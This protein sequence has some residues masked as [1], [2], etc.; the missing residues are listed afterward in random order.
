MPPINGNHSKQVK[1]LSS[2]EKFSWPSGK[3]LIVYHTNWSTYGRDYQVKDIPIEYISDINYAFYNLVKNQD[4]FYVPTTGDAWADMDQRFTTAEKGLSPL[5][6]WIK[7]EDFYGNFGQFRK[8]KENGHKF[9]LGLSVGGWS[10]SKNF[11]DALKDEESRH[12]FSDTIID[13]F[14]QYPIFNRIDLDWEYISPEGNSYGLPENGTRR[15]D[16]VNFGLFI[17]MLRE[18]FDRNGMEQYEITMCS[19]ADPKKLAILPIKEMV[20]YLDTINIMTYDFADGSWGLTRSTH[21]TNVYKT[22]YTPFSVEEAVDEFIRLGV[23]REKL[24]IGV[25]Y[26]SRGFSNT[27][28]INLPCSGGSTD[29]SW[30]KGV[31]DYKDLPLPGATEFYDELAGGAYSLDESKRILNTY[32]NPRSVIEKCKYVIDNDLKGII[33]WESSGDRPK[34]DDRCLT[35]IIHDN[36]SRNPIPIVSP[37]PKPVPVPAPRPVPPPVPIEEVI[38]KPPSSTPLIK[39]WMPFTK[40]NRNER[41]SYKEKVY[42]CRSQHVSQLDWKPDTT[43]TLWEKIGELLTPAPIPVPAPVKP[44]P[45]PRPIIIQPHPEHDGDCPYL[46][47]KIK[48]ITITSPVENIYF[49]YY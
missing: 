5:D 21:H 2:G 14:L 31:V 19:S 3:K 46:N 34:N 40:Y 37:V 44:T 25:A 1:G 41:V 10:W 4:G 13:I 6:N 22:D 28:G 32:D 27:T 26:Y 33:V 24:V 35:K 9:N 8:L 48:K 36:L 39:P 16:P 49:E 18:K 42:S 20:Q 30:E 15:E 29:T 23:P 45:A 17:K 11:S 47:K 38:P 12:E 7:N 43:T